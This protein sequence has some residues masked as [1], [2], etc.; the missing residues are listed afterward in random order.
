LH[1]ILYCF[2]C[3]QSANRAAGIGDEQGRLPARVKATEVKTKCTICS[4][5]IRVTKTNTEARTHYESR[6]PSFTF[7]VCFPDT[8]DPTVPA[9]V[10]DTSATQAA[11]AAAP[12]AA[13]PK[14]KKEDLSF[15]DAA[16]NPKK[17]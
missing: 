5:E 13:A 16:L 10:A 4:T 6:H 8:M 7:A 2:I 9:V 14:K 12:A 15:L 3:N 17:K 11:P 1:L